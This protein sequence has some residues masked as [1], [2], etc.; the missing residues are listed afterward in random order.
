[1]HH[2]Q[3]HSYIKERDLDF[4]YWPLDGQQGPSRQLVRVRARCVS[5]C[6][7]PPACRHAFPDI[8]YSLA[9][10]HHTLTHNPTC[11]T[12]SPKQG[13]EE[14]Y[15]LLNATWDGWANAELV[16]QLQAL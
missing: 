16:R 2:H 13:A 8:L 7:C 3:Q 12:H 5:A 9:A 15:G 6:V 11:T 14:T 1:M 4:A 10:L